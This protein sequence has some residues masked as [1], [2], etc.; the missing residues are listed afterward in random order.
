MFAVPIHSMVVMLEVIAE[1]IAAKTVD[2]AKAEARTK[3]F[4]EGAGTAE[5]GKSAL[6]VASSWLHFLL[7]EDLVTAATVAAVV[8]TVA[9][10][11]ET[12]AAMGMIIM[13]EPGVVSSVAVTTE[14]AISEAMTEAT[15]AAISEA[16]T[17]ATVVTV[18]TV[19]TMAAMSE[20]EVRSVA[21]MSEVMTVMTEIIK[22]AIK[23]SKVRVEFGATVWCNS[24]IRSAMEFS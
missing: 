11:A 2:A 14:V 12:V 13:S 16:M 22:T 18:A 21:A 17:V 19:T 10:M 15:V 5:E 6:N 4:T 3:A 8:I 20:A 23:S 24:S 7:T 9:S 1:E